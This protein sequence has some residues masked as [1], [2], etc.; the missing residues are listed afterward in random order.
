MLNKYASKSLLILSLVLL[1]SC[2]NVI[3]SKPDIATK[4]HSVNEMFILDID[5]LTPYNKSQNAFKIKWNL[6]DYDD[7]D[8][9]NHDE[10]EQVE[11]EKSKKIYNKI[12][13]LKENFPELIKIDDVILTDT[14]KS[15]LGINSSDS[16]KADYSIG[17]DIFLELK[18]KFKIF[19]L[20]SLDVF[21]FKY[22]DGLVAQSF[23][24]YL[25][26]GPVVID[27]SIL[28]TVISVSPT[29]VKLKINTT[30]IPV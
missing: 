13:E 9:N 17:K 6:S 16:I 29:S 18:G 22:E 24:G 1:T 23:V 4:D 25:P 2:G 15:I 8:K 20:L 12:K 21:N 19:P 27:N 11:D 7:H 14:N 10:H 3:N 28:C 26:L 30:A 5:G